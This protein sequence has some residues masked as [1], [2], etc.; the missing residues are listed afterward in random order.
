[1][2]DIS[3]IMAKI[4]INRKNFKRHWH[5]RYDSGELRLITH[6]RII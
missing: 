1:M 6:T 2:T 4:W 5:M 3:I